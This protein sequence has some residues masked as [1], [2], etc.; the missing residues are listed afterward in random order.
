[1]S[2]FRFLTRL[3]SGPH[4][5]QDLKRETLGVARIHCNSFGRRAEVSVDSPSGLS[6]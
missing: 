4:R 5:Y 6:A 3:T 1:M 2:D